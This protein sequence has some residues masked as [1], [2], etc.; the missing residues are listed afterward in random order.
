MKLLGR[1]IFIL[2]QLLF[3]TGAFASFDLNPR[4]QEA[5]RLIVRLRFDAADRLLQQERAVAPD[6][7]VRLMLECYRD[8]LHVFN[9]E[10]HE[11]FE[12]FKR[13]IPEVLKTLDTKPG[14]AASPFYL[15]AKCD[16][17]LQQTLLHIKFQEYV[18]AALD[19]RKAW[20]LIEKNKSKFPTFLLNSKSSGF[21]HA[22]VGAVPQQY[23]WVVEMSGMHGDL[24]KG[25]EELKRFILSVEGTGFECYQE[26]AL[27]CIGN[28]HSSLMPDQE[29]DAWMMQQMQL[30][31]KSN[32]LIRYSLACIQMQ[33]GRNDEALAL[34]TLPS[35]SGEHPLPFITY[36]LGL[37]RLQQLDLSS[38]ESFNR[39]LREFSGINY[40]KAAW[41]KIA[42]VHLLRNDIA[43]YRQAMESCKRVKRIIIDEDRE[44]QDEAVSGEV[45]N[46]H[47]LK[48]RLL[49]D[50]GYYRESLKAIAGLPVDSFPGFHN[51][52]EF[53]YRLGRIFQKLGQQ[54]KAISC[55]ES[56]LK[57]GAG[58]KWYYAANSALSLGLIYES[59]KD[60]A[61][62]ESYYRKCLS[63]RNHDYQ[64][65]IDQ[66]AKAGLERVSRK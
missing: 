43:R 30:H 65:S 37:A 64:N 50:G 14:N 12:A 45:P 28:I 44:A 2:L 54:D 9:D 31:Q 35:G 47:L 15:Y 40:I 21:L 18:S 13:K 4:M 55:F 66:K 32:P 27:Y 20:Q 8:F 17:M 56:T 58:S 63:L 41:Q 25:T 16:I 19:L 6:N 26:E 53:T 23:D 29:P 5:C 11:K 3:S 60:Y 51:Q 52:L 38:I 33:S 10:S 62:A 49:F 22:L 7:H 34:L 46:I 39:F 61:K 24:K 57:N 42:W 1:I 48:S 59:R 36:R